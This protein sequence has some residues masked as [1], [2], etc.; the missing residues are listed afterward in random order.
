MVHNI[1][2][3]NK[4]LTERITAMNTL[5]ATID[6]V[7]EKGYTESFNVTDAGL[8]IEGKDRCYTAGQV[9]VADF[10]RFEGES[11]P[12]DESVLYIIETLD[13]IKGVLIDAYGTYSNDKINDFMRLVTNMN[14]QDD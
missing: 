1:A 10:F 4:K 13:G 3:E 7:R 2:M 8:C 5:S 9:T 12:G 6:V 11:D 14:K